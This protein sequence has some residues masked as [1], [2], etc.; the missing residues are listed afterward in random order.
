MNHPIEGQVVLLATAKASVTGSRLAALLEDAQ[1]LLESDL[2]SYHRRYELATEDDDACCFFVPPDHWD[3]IG[4]R[5][6]LQR[7]EHEALRRAHEEQLKRLGKHENR[8]DEFETALEVR[9]AVV[10]GK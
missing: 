8:H 3:G 4:N 5:L 2:D 9:S 10:L 1:R 7:R 6:G